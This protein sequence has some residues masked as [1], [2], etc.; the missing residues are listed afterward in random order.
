MQQK[1]WTKPNFLMGI[2]SA[3]QLVD[4]FRAHAAITGLAFVGRSNVGKSSTI[5]TLF[6]KTTARVS[7]TPGR[8]RQI[9]IFEFYLNEKPDM[10]FYFFDLPGY[11]HAEITKQMRKNWDELM[12]A[13]FQYLSHNVLLLNIQ[14]ARHPHQAADQEF[15]EFFKTFDNETYV[16]YNKIDKLKSQKE[17]NELKNKMKP[18]YKQLKWVKQIHYF[19]AEKKTGLEEI[20]L[21]IETYLRKKT[22][23]EA[24]S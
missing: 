1:P 5:N 18:L 23:L 2:D 13:F 15:H 10:P 17:K 11:G 20:Q 14:D 9:N 8:T 4:W 24:K 19:S 7:K 21:A 22:N 12:G 3:E 6:G 16:I